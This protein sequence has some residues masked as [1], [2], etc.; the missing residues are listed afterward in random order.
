MLRSVFCIM[1]NVP[2][3]T[4]AT[5][6]CACAGDWDS[7][8]AR[9]AC[10]FVR[11]LQLKST[12]WAVADITGGRRKRGRAEVVGGGGGGGL[13]CYD[14]S[15]CGAGANRLRCVGLVISMLFKF[16][17][18]LCAGCNLVLNV[19]IC[20]RLF[21]LRSGQ[22][23]LIVYSGECGIFF[24]S[25]CYPQPSLAPQSALHMSFR[26]SAGHANLFEKQRC[27]KD[28]TSKGCQ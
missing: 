5:I 27:Y 3:L 11:G 4:A 20:A 19:E 23:C 10:V 1:N 15:C 13:R 2:G 28:L 18:G 21:F 17:C 8:L 14:S 6:D 16:C 25:V 24:L 12:W 9:G 7:V 22:M 26:I